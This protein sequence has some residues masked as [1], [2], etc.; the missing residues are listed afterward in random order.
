MLRG[1]IVI[2]SAILSKV[3][4]STI[5]RLALDVS[6]SLCLDDQIFLKRQLHAHNILGVA[7]TAVGLAVVG[8][9]AVL[10]DT[11][12]GKGSDTKTVLFGCT[13]G[14]SC[15]TC[16]LVLTT[17][18]SFCR[19]HDHLGAVHVRRANGGR[20]ILMLFDH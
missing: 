14:V 5:P 8:T 9:A 19:C 20:S 7:L 16:S 13:P 3:N 12:S 2:F 10:G 6:L 4:S 1:S 17:L 18:G 15:S 11:S